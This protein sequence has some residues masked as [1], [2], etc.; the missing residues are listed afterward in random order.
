MKG[1]VTSVIK[2]FRFIEITYIMH[3][4][5]MF[6]IFAHSKINYKHLLLTV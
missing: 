6:Q 3:Y 1:F 2:I 5:Y 4:I